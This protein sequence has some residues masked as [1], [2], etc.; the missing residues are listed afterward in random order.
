VPTVADAPRLAISR[1]A[2]QWWLAAPG[3]P[4]VLLIALQVPVMIQESLNDCGSFIKKREIYMLE[5]V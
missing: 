4:A 5:I 3:K 2:T 1:L